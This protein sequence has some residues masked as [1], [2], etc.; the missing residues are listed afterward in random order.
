MPKF[1]SSTIIK[2]LIDVAEKGVKVRVIIHKDR[3]EQ[4]IL[5]SQYLND[6][7]VEIKTIEPIEK[8]E[9]EFI[10]V[11]V[12]LSE[13]EQK[14]EK[15]GVTLLGALNYSYRF[16][17]CHYD[18]TLVSSDPKITRNFKIEFDRV[19]HSY[20]LETISISKQ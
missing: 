20:T 7:G 16:V 11:D 2:C 3:S 4:Q 18:S 9:H 5:Y 17:N 8:L 10:L 6:N 1:T 12:D 19:W 15:S 14:P 13:T